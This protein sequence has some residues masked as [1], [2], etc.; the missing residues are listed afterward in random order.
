MRA[1]VELPRIN[2]KV[3]IEKL[4]VFFPITD[5]SARE[6]YKHL[7]PVFHELFFPVFNLIHSGW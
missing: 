4:L 7:V 6:E 2:I 3:I 5:P 1:S